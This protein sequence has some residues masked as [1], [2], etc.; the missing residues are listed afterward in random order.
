MDDQT[1]SNSDSWT[2]KNDLKF[3][4]EVVSETD[5]HAE[6]MELKGGE[7]DFRRRGKTQCLKL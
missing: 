3:N 1:D 5:R 7:K 4:W 6:K 2:D